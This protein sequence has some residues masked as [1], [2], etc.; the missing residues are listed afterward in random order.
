MSLQTHI[1]LVKRSAP[2]GV[3]AACPLQGNERFYDAPTDI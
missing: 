2:S 1:R 3:V